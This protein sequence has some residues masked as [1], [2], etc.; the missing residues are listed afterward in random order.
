MTAM[1]KNTTQR[2]GMM[3]ERATSHGG[4]CGWPWG[5]GPVESATLVA[6]VVL[7]LDAVP[8][9]VNNA[10]PVAL[11]LDDTSVACATYCDDV[12]VIELVGEAVAVFLAPF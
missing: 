11:A 7:V 12:D 4:I 2:I 8:A 1:T 5:G 9:T 10:S 6:D 3:T